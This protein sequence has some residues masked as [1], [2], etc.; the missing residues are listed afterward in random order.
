M[1]ASSKSLDIISSKSKTYY[2][3]ICEAA[4][5]LISSVHE[6][7]YISA[8]NDYTWYKPHWFRDASWVSTSLLIYSDFIKQID[9]VSSFKAL[10]AASKIIRFNIDSIIQFMPNIISLDNIPFEN[11]EFFSLMHHM[12]S[13]VDANKMR[14]IGDSIDDTKE[15]N[16]MHSWL[17]QYDT[18]PLILYS[19]N[20]KSKLF[21]LDNFETLFLNKYV[22][23]IAS[24]LGKIY[25]TEC[26]SA[27]EI[28]SNLLH[29]YDVAAVYSA[30]SSLKELSQKYDISIDKEA[31]EKIE[32]SL[33]PGGPLAF[34]KK[35]FIHSNVLYNE[36]EPFK[37]FPIVEKGLDA[38]EIFIFSNFGITGTTLG[39]ESIEESTILEMER[40]LFSGNKL[41]IRF[42]GDTY[43]KGGRWLLLGLAFAEYYIKKGYIEKASDIID[44]VIGKYKSSYPEQEV[45]NPSSPNEDRG[46]FFALNGYKPIQNLAW[47]YAAVIMST[48]S[49][50]KYYKYKEINMLRRT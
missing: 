50:L 12:P 9:P 27:W 47:S 21:G 24:Y 8:S 31:I 45:V 7:G 16:T 26:A 40:H 28:D 34:I 19:I 2:S 18:I 43:Y 33:F 36:K 13:R 49:L 14:Y 11:S 39:N 22:P 38:S 44:Y 5:Y 17:I 15:L 3:S 37:D 25:I 1:D 30:F 29:A 6:N 46:N 48:V 42:K 10:Q 41:P 23:E 35:F 4:E 32:G 20:I